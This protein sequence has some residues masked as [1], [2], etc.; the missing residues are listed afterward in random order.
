MNQ[1]FRLSPILPCPQRP[2]NPTPRAFKLAQQVLVLDIVDF[3]AQV[4]V[5]L[6]VG[7]ALE[8]ELQDRQHVRDGGLRERRLAPEGE[9]A[10]G[11]C[12][13]NERSV[14]GGLTYPPMNSSSSPGTR[15]SAILIGGGL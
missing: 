15:E 12:V 8:V 5:L 14:K 11:V 7:H 1:N 13:S 4:F 6:P 3:D 10:G 2:L 9:D